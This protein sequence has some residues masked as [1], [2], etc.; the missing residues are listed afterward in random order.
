MTT[1]SPM[2]NEPTLPPDAAEISTSLDVMERAATALTVE[3]PADYAYVAEQVKKANDYAKALEEKRMEL[4]RPLDQLK[5]QWMALFEPRTAAANRIV[6]IL[7]SKLLA[8]DQEQERKRRAA[9]EEARRKREE[10]ERRAAEQARREREEIER[11]ERE[12]RE[13][14]A[15]ER[16]AAEQRAAAAAADE[17]ARRQAEADAAAAR[18]REQDAAEQAARDRE[19]LRQ[20]EEAQ[21]FMP[22][23]VA[24]E[25]VPA[26][27]K[28]SGVSKRTTWKVKSVDLR[29]LIIGAAKALEAGDD[30]LL[31]LLVPATVELNKRVR[32][33]GEHTR[34]PG[35]F[36]EPESNL[37]VGRGR[38]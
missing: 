30:S 29:A 11:R 8:F 15:A 34:I 18:Q 17:R 13:A 22:A 4:T 26:A 20:R 1:D 14:A 10:E 32:A 5:K 35:V 27:P 7:K 24:A 2:T 37:A 6:G 33:L 16:R 38:K 19:A 25:H 23:P 31:P 36:V 12:A 3:T 9:E 28:V 21:R